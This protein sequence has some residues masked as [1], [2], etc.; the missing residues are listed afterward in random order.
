MAQINLTLSEE[1]LLQVL[2]GE[3]DEAMKLIVQKV[4]NE[5]M[6][7]ESE[8]QI[9]AGRHE[10][11]DGRTDYRNGTRERPLTTRIGTITLSVPR[12][13]NQ[14]FHTMVFENYSRSEAAL[15][16][17]MTEMVVSGISTRKISRVTELLCGKSFSKSTVSELCARISEDIERFRERVLQDEYPFLVVDATYFKARVD[18]RITA[19]AFMV[20]MGV[21]ADGRRE[22]LDF[23]IYENESNQTWGDFLGRLRKRGVKDVCMV[24][25]DAHP[26]IL[27]ACAKVYPDAAWQ[28]CQFHFSRNILEAVTK[29]EY[30]AGLQ[31]ELTEMFHAPT[32][33]GA[34]TIKNRIV[35]D[36]Q[37]VAEKAMDI[38]E[39]GFEDAMTVLELP[40]AYR[41]ILRTSNMVE[42]LNGELKRRAN[43]I[44]VFPDEASILRLMGA[45]AIEYS[46]RFVVSRRMVY[47]AAMETLASETRKVLADLAHRQK[48]LLYAA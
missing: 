24:V 10:R 46:D 18:H 35:S 14:P 45:V 19:R 42:R 39:D 47:S 37:D 31:T 23:G 40:A 44:R 16:A 3:H 9:G 17:A 20:A 22:V 33:A 38:L 2:S 21:R 8:E 27:H 12:H 26:A 36:Y 4:L 5:I 6:L 11:T 34:R 43:V 13:R 1:E 29:K 28:R 15:I 32:I 41:K 7:A 30:R 25:S 48:T